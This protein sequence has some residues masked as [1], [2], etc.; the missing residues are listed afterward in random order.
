MTLHAAVVAQMLEAEA[1]SVRQ[2][3][4]GEVDDVELD[5]TRVLIRPKTWAG[6]WMCLDGTEYDQRPLRL[7]ILDAERAPTDNWPGKLRYGSELHPILQ[8]PWACIRGTYQYHAYPGHAAETWD[9][10]RISIRMIHLV[11]HILKN[12]AS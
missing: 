12:A 3:L 8:E 7:S 11:T 4:S 5:G 10:F 2:S 1:D 9:Q 6:S